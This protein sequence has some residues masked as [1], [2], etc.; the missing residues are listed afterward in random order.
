ME[1]AAKAAFT[2]FAHNFKDEV[3]KTNH[4][5]YLNALEDS[6]FVLEDR[7]AYVSIL[8]LFVPMSRKITVGRRLNDKNKSNR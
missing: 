5:W 3:A 8:S 6:K 7:E 4:R 1:N 2:Y